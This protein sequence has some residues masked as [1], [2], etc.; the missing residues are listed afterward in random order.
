MKKILF[1]LTL[2]SIAEL[3]AQSRV[4]PDYNVIKEN[5]S[6]ENSPYFYPTLLQKY[7]SVNNTFTLEEKLHLYY[8]FVFQSWYNPN[9]TTIEEKEIRKVVKK[10]LISKTEYRDVV[11]LADMILKTNPFNTYALQWKTVALF[12]LD[13]S[14]SVEYDQTTT[15][16]NIIMDAILSSGTG[17]SREN[18]YWVIAVQHEYELLNYLDYTPT[19][20]EE[21][22]TGE[23][24]YDYITLAENGDKI[25]GFYF[26]ITPAHQH[27]K[28][29]LEQK[30]KK[31]NK[32][33]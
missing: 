17:K 6:D 29:M 33:N 16:Y 14:N 20:Q 7:F 22:Q 8:G 30:N 21:V 18:A 5:I 11:Q 13:R 12:K 32:K 2:L 27:L 26:E 23:Q 3:S 15:Q 28:N 4:A 25:A 19:E 31:R 24:Y 9:E 1:F 10:K